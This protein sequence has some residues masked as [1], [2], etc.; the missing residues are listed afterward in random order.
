MG[1]CGLSSFKFEPRKPLHSPRNLRIMLKV[2]KEICRSR[3]SLTSFLEDVQNVFHRKKSIAVAVRNALSITNDCIVI[4]ANALVIF[5]KL[6]RGEYCFWI[7]A[8]GVVFLLKWW[9]FRRLSFWRKT[10]TGKIFTQWSSTVC[11]LKVAVW[12]P[13]Y[14]G[15]HN[16]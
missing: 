5:S 15:M 12:L 1:S 4:W 3:V 16:K 10:K 11:I 9:N 8:E 6:Y 13:V 2:D 14:K 7:A